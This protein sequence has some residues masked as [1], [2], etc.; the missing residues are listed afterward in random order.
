MTVLMAGLAA[1]TAA[2][3]LSAG[4]VAAQG[5]AA[6][7]ALYGLWSNPKHTVQVDIRPC[8]LSACGYVVWASAEAQADARKGGTPNLIGLQVLRDMK[9]DTGVWAGKVFVPDLNMTFS[10]KAMLVDPISLRA[11]GCIL[12]GLICKSQKWTRAQWPVAAS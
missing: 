1:L 10:G 5:V 9:P 8:G 4:P 7:N 6:Q 12:G 3:S 2:F 11:K